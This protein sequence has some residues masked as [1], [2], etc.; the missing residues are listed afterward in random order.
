MLI[1]RL[2][3]LRGF[4]RAL[5]PTLDAR[6]KDKEEVRQR[7]GKL[8]R[9]LSF[10]SGHM[11]P[12]SIGM[13]WPVRAQ[14]NLVGPIRHRLRQNIV[15]Q[16]FID[17]CV[18][19]AFFVALFLQH[20]INGAASHHSCCVRSVQ[21]FKSLLQELTCNIGN[22]FVR[23]SFLWENLRDFRTLRSIPWYP[24]GRY[25]TTACCA[26]VNSPF[27]M[28][29][30]V[31][32]RDLPLTLPMHDKERISDAAVRASINPK[33]LFNHLHPNFPPESET[34]LT[35]SV[36]RGLVEIF[37][38]LAGD[39]RGDRRAISDRNRLFVNEASA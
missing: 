2:W 13:S 8:D 7:F 30:T 32:P 35:V 4:L 19:R 29:L 1:S 10:L 3:I 5:D 23:S 36:E 18:E 14:P 22:I 9:L 11:G 16:R 38:T 37:Q 34:S 33:K 26:K 20:C 39:R 21:R 31:S 17:A 15:F 6:G 28:F 25:S 12:F 27:G 24:L